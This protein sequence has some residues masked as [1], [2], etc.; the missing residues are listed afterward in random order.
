[1]PPILRVAACGLFA[2]QKCAPNI[3]PSIVQGK[4][5]QNVTEILLQIKRKSFYRNQNAP[6]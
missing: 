5:S 3:N 1:M 2:R 6:T 4:K